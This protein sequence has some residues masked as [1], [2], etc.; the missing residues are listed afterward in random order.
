MSETLAVSPVTEALFWLF[1]AL[2][3]GGAVLVVTVRDVFKAAVFL[4]GSFIAVAAIYFILQAE[5]IGVV[6]ILVYAGAVSI[7][8]AFAVM[9]IADVPGGSRP[10]KGRI[11]A[12][13]AAGLMFA[14]L[15]FTAYNTGWTDIEQVT[16]ENAVAGL[17]GAYYEEEPAGSE[18]DSESAG[19][20]VIR[21]AEEGSE[22]A[23]AGALI[24]STGTIGTLLIREF[25]LPFEILG[26]LLTAALIGGL[27]VMRGVRTTDK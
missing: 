8:I 2:A 9:I 21:A 26:L 27:A 15:A 25:V 6:Q 24:D 18:D 23:R 12:A 1:S 11:L 13:A 20:R 22:G 17:T 14:A 5:F 4:A 16:D 19:A 3:I 10:A 7:L